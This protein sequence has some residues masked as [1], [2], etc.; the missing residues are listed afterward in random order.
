MRTLGWL[1][2][3]R[4][5]VVEIHLQADWHGQSNCLGLP[6]LLQSPST[7]LPFICVKSSMVRRNTTP[8]PPRLPVKHLCE[9][10]NLHQ[11]KGLEAPVV[12]LADPTG[13]S[14]HELEVHI[15]RSE[16]PA[17]GYM[18]IYGQRNGF[19]RP[20]LAYPEQWQELKME[21]GKFQE[22]EINRLLY[23]AATRAGNRLVITQRQRSNQRNPWAPLNAHLENCK[24]LKRPE[25]IAPFQ[26]SLVIIGDGEPAEAT[27]A[28]GDRW[29]KTVERSYILAA[30]KAISVSGS[31]KGPTTGEHG[32]EWGTVIHAILEAAMRDSHANFHDLAY[33]SLQHEG[34]DPA[35]ADEVIAVVQSVMNSEIW[36]RAQASDH[37]LIEV[38]FQLLM[39]TDSADV[40]AL[41]T[42]LRGV[43]DLAFHEPKGWVIVDYK[44]DARPMS[45]VPSLVEHYRGQVETYADAW[46]SMTGESVAEKGLYFTHVGAYSTVQRPET[47]RNGRSAS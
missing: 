13:E 27:K 9:L 11:A 37:R 46:R 26:E 14:S 15:D 24:Q 43:I 30:A 36:K 44:T 10:M 32:T 34:L 17:R 5:D 40:N 6:K 41:P 47:R 2:V 7:S 20:L 18:A 45:H 25:V 29:K 23:V 42:L 33:A 31:V 28:V 12:F 8:F 19:R 16:G 4:Q 21:E 39:P 22:A 3:R 38:P 35:L 1:P